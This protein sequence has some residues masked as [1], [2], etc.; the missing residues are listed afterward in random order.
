MK[1][2]GILKAGGKT[3]ADVGLGGTAALAEGYANQAL[4]DLYKKFLDDERARTTQMAE[5]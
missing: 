1:A 2:T 4:V 3:W 5:G